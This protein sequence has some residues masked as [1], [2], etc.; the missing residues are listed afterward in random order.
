M[1]HKIWSELDLAILKEKYPL[2]GYLLCQEEGLKDRTRD[3]IVK[4][5]K[6]LNLHSECNVKKIA[7][8][9]SDMELKIMRKHYPVGG[10]KECLKL[11]NRSES[12]IRLKAHKLGL[13]VEYKDNT[14]KN[15]SDYELDI[16][17]ECYPKGGS[18]LCR[19]KGI[20][21]SFYAINSKARKLNIFREYR[22]VNTV[23]NKR[24]TKEE[25]KVLKEN[26]AKY[27]AIGCIEKGIEGRT[28][29]SII[30]KATSLGIKRCKE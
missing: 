25:E 26:F 22:Y 4:K 9:W 17:R 30:K 18:V 10:I 29:Y 27:G 20:K 1:R 11:L 6:E 2:G 19:E 21:R 12:S 8:S 24:W 14:F 5:A 13:K 23:K 15:W 28:K 3:A 16:L 7:H